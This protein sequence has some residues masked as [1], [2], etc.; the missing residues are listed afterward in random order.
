MS[1]VSSFTEVPEIDISGLRS[2]DPRRRQQVVDLLGQIAQASDDPGLVR[3]A[4]AAVQAVSR[5][6]VAAIPPRP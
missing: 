6:V 2:T 1:G 4:R 3:T 5:G